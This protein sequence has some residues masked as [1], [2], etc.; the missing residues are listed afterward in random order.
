MIHEVAISG[1]RGIRE[2]RLS[3]LSPLVVLAGPNGCGKSTVLDALLMGAGNEPGDDVGRAVQRRPDLWNGARW[4]LPRHTD[5]SATVIEVARQRGGQN[6]RRVSKLSWR[7]TLDA[8]MQHDLSIQ[9][10]QVPVSGNI[11]IEVDSPSG[12]T[13]AFV[14]FLA[15]NTYQCKLSED[16]VTRWETKII[17]IPHGSN[18][19]LDALF[20]AATQSGRQ[21]QA[22]IV[23]QAVFGDRIRDIT[24]LTDKAA[25]V[26]YLVTDQGNVPITAAGEGVACLFR[27]ALDLAT[28]SHGLVLIEEPETHQHPRMMAQTAIL[29]WKAVERG[30]QVVLTTHSIAFIDALRTHAPTYAQS[31][32]SI[33][34]LALEKGHLSAQRIANGDPDVMR[35]AIEQALG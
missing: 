25:P 30:V 21:E 4:L 8:D 11:T 15:D 27:I 35:T 14:G 22:L 28:T 23:L 20:I 26:V 1:L 18:Q 32:L 6:E 7:D 19:P 16:R 29:I 9:R 17:D 33:Q 12:G 3:D 2:G 24:V 13:A 10:P 5:Q 31:D 34:R